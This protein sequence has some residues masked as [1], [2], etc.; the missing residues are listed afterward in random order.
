M[1]PL[2]WFRDHRIAVFPIRPGTKEPA[3]QG[4]W[5]NWDDFARPRPTGPYGVVLGRVIVV[6]T[7]TPDA[8]ASI[9][10]ALPPTPFMVRAA[11][12]WH[13]YFRAPEHP[14]PAT[15]YRA[16]LAIECRRAGQYVVGPGSLHKDGQHI[17]TASSWSWA[18][19]DLPIF[20]ASFVFDD[21]A[22]AAAVA[23][24]DPPDRILDG[25]R[26]HE[27]FRLI[28]HLKGLQS[29]QAEARFIVGTYNQNRCDN[30]LPEDANFEAW[31]RRAWALRDR[32]MPVLFDGDGL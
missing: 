22:D 2:D 5:A 20:P 8:E 4:H 32:P 7:D 10:A 31:F 16:G 29:S 11:R 15:I 6:D 9:A 19:T 21:R 12:G 30:P 24:Y 25:E 13:R 14:T 3:T 23:G 26:H 27:L 18:W 28:R 1:N 17:Y